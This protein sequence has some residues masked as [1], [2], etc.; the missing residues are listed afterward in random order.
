MYTFP[1]FCD[2]GKPIGDGIYWPT[3]KSEQEL[4]QRQSQQA[5]ERAAQSQVVQANQGI[6]GMNQPN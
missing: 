2:S 1:I 6:G 5:A 4:A 3:I